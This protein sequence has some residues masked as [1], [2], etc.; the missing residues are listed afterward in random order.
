[1]VYSCNIVYTYFF[2]TDNC[3]NAREPLSINDRLKKEQCHVT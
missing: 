1:M 3:K 2:Y